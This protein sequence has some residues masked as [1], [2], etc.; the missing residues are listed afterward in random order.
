MTELERCTA[1]CTR[2]HMAVGLSRDILRNKELWLRDLNRTRVVLVLK[3]NK[4]R[5]E[6]GEEELKGG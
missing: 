3:E 1:E 5:R 6:A 4:R 2:A